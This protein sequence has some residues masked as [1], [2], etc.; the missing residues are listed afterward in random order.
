[1][2]KIKYEFKEL[3]ID[4]GIFPACLVFFIMIPVFIIY[5]IFYPFI[6]FNAWSRSWFKGD[7]DEERYN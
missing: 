2:K 6:A 3:C 5:I 7:S 4:M 1:M